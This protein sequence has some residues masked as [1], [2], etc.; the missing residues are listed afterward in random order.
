[1]ADPARTAGPILVLSGDAILRERLAGWLRAAALPTVA[2]ADEAEATATLTG[3]PVALLVV[4]Q[5]SGGPG[6]V[7]RLR[8][9][10]AA[11]TS[12]P[13]L[14]L[15]A[16][17][18]PAERAEAFHLDVVD[19]CS[20]GLGA[21]ELLTRVRRLQLLVAGSAPSAP[22]TLSDDDPTGGTDADPSR[23]G[24][25]LAQLQEL[26]QLGSWQ[27]DLATGALSWSATMRRLFGVGEHGHV[28][29]EVFA[30]RVHPEDR[31]RVEAAWQAAQEAG[32]PYG[33]D[34][35][36]V[37][38]GQVRWIRAQGCFERDSDGRTTAAMGVA[39]D[40]TERKLGEQQ[41]A[42]E[43][44]RLAD[45]FEAA[46]AS[47]W[48]WHLDTDEL[49]LDQRTD[50]PGIHL[51]PDDD[52]TMAAVIMRI[53]PE[54][55][56]ETREAMLALLNGT[57]DRY[58]AEFRLRRSA[59]EWIWL[60]AL[61]RIVGR[62]VDGTPTL[63]RGI[64]LDITG[65]RAQQEQVAF[66]Q[67]HDGLT[68]LPNRQGFTDTLRRMLTDDPDA[69]L[70]VI[71]VDLD[72][73]EAV[74][75]AH[76]RAAGNL[77][78]AE[79]A[80]RL[81][82]L[83]AARDHLAR[84][85]GDEFSLVLR[86]AEDELAARAE[87]LHELLAAPIPL[88]SGPMTLTASLGLTTSPQPGST[89]DA[90]QLLRQ[91][92]QA[93]YQ[94]KLSGKNRT[95]RFDLAHHEDTRARFLL[96]DELAHAIADGQLI[97][98]YQ[99]QVDLRTGRVLGAEALVRWQHPT[100]GLLSP[101]AF[102]P[103]T[104]DHPIA[105]ELGTH[106]LDV[107]LTQLEVWQ[108]RGL[109]DLTIAVN[110]DALQLEDPDFYARTLRQVEAHPD[111]RREQLTLEILETGAPEDLDAVAALID[112]FQAVGIM[113]ALDDFGT[114]FASLTFLR[115]LGAQL[116]KIDRSFTQGLVDD[117]EDAMIVHAITTLSHTM[118]RTAFA[119]GVETTEQGQRL[120]QLGC[121]LGQGYHI[122]RPMP[123]DE[124]PA[125]I[126]RWQPPDVWRT[127]EPLAADELPAL[128]DEL[129]AASTG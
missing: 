90:D 11:G 81:L 35:R 8:S 104:R 33:L 64:V 70:A 100:R 101:W 89:P 56:A 54:D 36:L 37:V 15:T 114:G 12:L 87:E 25:G 110:T 123:G 21:T 109:T 108:A 28:D 97:A 16:A 53:H 40:I 3:Q 7:Q 85:G 88:R 67:I 47:T 76:G 75:H 10:T 113:V 91:A 43:R 44:A 39:F 79:L 84:T 122:A 32:R 82:P 77:V 63:V 99:P 125:W 112:R 55:V 19:L 107:A 102:I 116:V 86:L 78:L 111:L 50:G 1:M 73:F 74:N 2:V 6:L 49:R 118:G 119:E 105:V 59:S 95:H 14:L 45:A 20:R 80:T 68:G 117:P 61:G 27:M 26:A 23:A 65:M 106:I 129:R 34:H 103:A 128:L 46:Q 24:L 57:H 98:H 41:L 5:P 83:V 69:E 115:R 66:A 42:A 62:E 4:D 124:L 48:E 71:S 58:H 121:T 72:D 93:V 127:T 60:R 94:A 92:D 17:A 18:D 126:D 52:R 30:S 51:L 22:S 9:A 38:D 13:A 31:D 96:L 120:I 29:L